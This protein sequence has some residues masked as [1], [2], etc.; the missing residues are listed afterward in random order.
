M[1]CLFLFRLIVLMH[2]H[3]YSCCILSILGQINRSNIY[4]LLKLNMYKPIWLHYVNIKNFSYLIVIGHFSSI[5]LFCSPCMASII[6]TNYTNSRGTT[7][8]TLHNSI[9]I[10]KKID[11]MLLF[12]FIFV[13]INS[14]NVYPL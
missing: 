12:I 4:P 1:L 6:F 10:I 3:Y 5:C 9:S 11:F 8:I 7:S 14:V 13:Q 2:S